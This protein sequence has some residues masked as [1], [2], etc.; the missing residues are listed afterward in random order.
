MKNI[1]GNLGVGIA[2]GIG[3]ILSLF[4]QSPAFAAEG[5]LILAHGTAMDHFAE[6]PADKSQCELIHEHLNSEEHGKPW[7]KAI[8]DVTAA[9]A[10]AI[11]KPLE[12]AFG[13]FSLP[14]FQHAVNR[15]GKHQ[16]DTLKII[17]FY[18]SSASGVIRQQKYM[19]D[20]VSKFFDDEK[21]VLPKSITKVI[22]QNAMDQDIEL[23]KV[24]YSR[25]HEL[26]SNPKQEE[27]IFVAHGPV[28]QADDDIWHRDLGL[29][30]DRIQSERAKTKSEFFATHPFTLKDD[31]PPEERDQRTKEL[32]ELVNKINARGNRPLILP[33]L[34]AAGGIE[35]GL[36]E[37]LEGLNY[38]YL[39]HMLTPDPE[40]IQ[41]IINRV[42]TGN[43]K[44]IK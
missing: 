2:V 22:F 19:F 21:I 3:L 32:R 4:V 41:W 10:K 9:A 33:V 7:E 28:Q 14:S 12:T 5:V 40:F 11:G 37:R 6:L 27:V 39:G 13:M 42:Q 24:L 36:L 35:K 38:H 18:V 25:A 44:K 1:F 26:S 29:H 30:A 16:I 20:V 31:A 34:V 8:C 15:L 43:I 17:P 23:T